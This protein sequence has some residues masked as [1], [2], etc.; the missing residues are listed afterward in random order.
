MKRQ[1][2][3]PHRCRRL[4]SCRLPPLS[5]VK[6]SPLRPL[7]SFSQSSLQLDQLPPAASIDTSSS[8][9][10]IFPRNSSCDFPPNE[11]AA[12]LLGTRSNF[13]WKKFSSYC[14]SYF[15]STLPLLHSYTLDIVSVSRHLLSRR[16]YV[17]VCSPGGCGSTSGVADRHRQKTIPPRSCLFWLLG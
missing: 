12:H 16:M 3:P 6:P 15:A 5:S 8:S 1:D 9:F 11:P 13:I 10:F 17:Y 2:W 4:R 7:S 14:F